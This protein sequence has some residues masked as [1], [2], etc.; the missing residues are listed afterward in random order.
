MRLIDAA[1]ERGTW[2]GIIKGMWDN[3]MLAPDA[4]AILREVRAD[5]GWRPL[6]MKDEGIFSALISLG[7]IERR[8]WLF[9]SH[10]DTGIRPSKENYDRLIAKAMALKK[11]KG[12]TPP[13]R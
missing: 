5:K 12:G 9:R 7:A 6:T 13:A 11:E 3:G 4:A 1:I 10:H 8:G 2:S